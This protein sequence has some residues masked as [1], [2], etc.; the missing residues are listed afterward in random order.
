MYAH[1]YTQQRTDIAT[2]K[3][4][5][6]IFCLICQYIQYRERCE[7]DECVLARKIK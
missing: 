4:L 3:F 2:K 1:L 6:Y 7:F 5:D